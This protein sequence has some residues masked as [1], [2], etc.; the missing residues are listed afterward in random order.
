MSRKLIHV[1]AAAIRNSKG[2]FLIAK[3]ADSQ[4]QGG[5]WEFPGGKVESDEEAVSAL[6][7]ELHEEL[8]IQVLEA[9][10]LIKVPYHYSDKSVLL[11]VFEVTKYSG[12]P[13]GRE[14]QPVQ[15]V[16]KADL[17]SFSFPAA[18]TPII[19]ACLLP[20]SIA[21]TPV[22]LTADGIASFA[23]VAISNGAEAIM[24]R[25]HAL[26]NAEFIHVYSMLEPLCDRLGVL[27]IANTS[28]AIGNECGADA[29]HLSSIR[30]AELEGREQFSGRWLSA[31]CHGEV[32]LKAAIKKGVDF[33][34]L[35]PVKATYSHPGAEPLG[36][37][38]F[39]SLADECP[40]PVYALGGLTS[41]DLRKAQQ[42][43][44]QG[45]AA[46][47]SWQSIAPNAL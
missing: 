42:C 8:G 29:L 21:I 4:H 7:R 13:W 37:D 3:R 19:D 6:G 45:I 36:W 17:E 20:S 22:D 18:N 24:L 12:D 26:T 43:G 10:P 32:E 9:R 30:L 39:Q 33:V 28:L 14:G 23:K 25:A 40:I 11:D 2:E 5:L 1:A 35:S 27:L 47:R 38:V 41:H 44:G 31:S 46:I 15:W 34:T 16:R